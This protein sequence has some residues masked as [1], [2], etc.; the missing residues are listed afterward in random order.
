[1]GNKLEVTSEF[2]K[3]RKETL[4]IFASEVY[5]DIPPAPKKIEA[6]EKAIEGKNYFCGHARLLQVDLNCVLDNETDFSFSFKLCLPT[7]VYKNKIIILVNFT[8]NVPDKYCPAEEIIDRGWAFAS[9]D[10]QS[11]TSDTNT[12]DGLASVYAPSGETGKLSLWAWGAMRIM[13]YLQT[14][15]DIDI[16][17]VGI[18]GHSRLGKTALWAAANDQRFRFV[19]SNDSGTSGAALYRERND[20]S[21]SIKD[22][23]DRFPYWFNKTFPKYIDM[24]SKMTFDQDDLIKCIA[25]RI[26]SIG[27]A[28]E[29]L[30]ANPRAEMLSAKNASIAWKCLGERGLENISD[31]AQIGVNYHDGKVGYYVREGRHCLSRNDWNRFLDFFDKNICSLS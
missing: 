13:D 16:A 7:N 9:F 19:H 15:D 5:G 23:C 14:R 10:Y 27:S 20:K 22:I 3:Q 28:S 26:V 11:I 2:I 1:M 18:V 21:E 17:N 8:P 25:P 30:W 6:I 31:E 4:G 12:P 24:E 29:D